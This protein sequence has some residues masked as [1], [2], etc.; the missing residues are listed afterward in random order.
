MRIN[1]RQSVPSKKGARS[2]L[3]A[4]SDQAPLIRLAFSG[5]YPEKMPFG[6]AS[7]ES[8]VRPA[9][10]VQGPV[11]KTLGSHFL[12]SSLPAFDRKF[13]SIR[14]AHGAALCHLRGS[15]FIP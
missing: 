13:D 6:G 9:T 1:L 8:R 12:C 4:I 11:M 3:Q 2:T 10:V 5:R 7:C 14:A 15:Q